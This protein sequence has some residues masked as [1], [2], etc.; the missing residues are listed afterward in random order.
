MGF[1]DC[2]YIGN[3]TTFSSS[4]IEMAIA[5]SQTENV[6]KYLAGEKFNKIFACSQTQIKLQ[7]GLFACLHFMFQ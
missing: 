5:K 2:W 7:L 6:Y 4:E 1:S 3:H